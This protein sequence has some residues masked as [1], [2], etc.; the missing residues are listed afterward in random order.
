MIHSLAAN[1][2]GTVH[3]TVPLW[4]FLST[5]TIP[6]CTTNFDIFTGGAAIFPASGT[7]G[8]ARQPDSRLN[9][10]GCNK[11][12]GG[13]REYFHVGVVNLQLGLA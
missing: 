13:Y 2:F 1:S 9:E 8:P 3:V 11:Q 4:T 7:P 6:G 5:I 12:A 10:A